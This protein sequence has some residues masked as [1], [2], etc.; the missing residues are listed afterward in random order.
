MTTKNRAT[1]KRSFYI[2]FSP[3]SAHL[4]D[5]KKLFLTLPLSDVR[6]GANAMG[7]PSEG[8]RADGKGQ[9]QTADGGQ[10]EVFT[11]FL[12]MT[13]YTPSRKMNLFHRSLKQVV[14]L[15]FLSKKNVFFIFFI[16][17]FHFLFRLFVRL[18]VCFFVF[19]SF[20]CFFSIQ[21]N[22]IQ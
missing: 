5:H 3:P 13:L 4:P 19:A 7:A 21:F 18:L 9:R 16:I 11:P 2:S 1:L 10:T 22:S 14:N 12:D 17:L 6:P 8:Q 20:F 15:S